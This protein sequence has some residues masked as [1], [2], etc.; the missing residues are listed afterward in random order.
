MKASR[1][2][3]KSI[4]ITPDDITVTFANQFES[5]ADIAT[6]RVHTG[7]GRVGKVNIAISATGEVYVYDFNKVGTKAKHLTVVNLK[8]SVG[9]KP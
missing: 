9:A 3:S 7:D 5:S 8:C 4:G 6:I 1:I 2:A